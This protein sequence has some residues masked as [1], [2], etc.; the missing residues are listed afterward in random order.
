MVVVFQ[1][2][3]TKFEVLKFREVCL[4]NINYSVLK[5]LLKTHFQTTR[6]L[7][8]KKEKLEEE[9]CEDV[10]YKLRKRCGEGKYVMTCR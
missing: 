10:K 2:V 7:C 1:I 9:E 8:R 4:E 3:F 6:E 5:A